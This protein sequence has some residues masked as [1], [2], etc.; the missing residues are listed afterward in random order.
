MKHLWA[1]WRRGY[2]HSL[3]RPFD[4]PPKDKGKE[5]GCL[6]CRAHKSDRRR[7][8]LGRGKNALVMMNLYP[9]AAGHLMVAPRRHVARPGLLRDEELLELWQWV[10]QSMRHLDQALHAEGYNIGVNIGRPAGAGIPG[11]MHIHVVPRWNGDTNFMPV[12]AS[13]KVI[14]DSMDSLY[15]ELKNC[16]SAGKN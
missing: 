6:F 9:Y 3:T 1:P 7:W 4:R 13:T 5:K 8:V 14:S 15:R 11:H 10:N 12:L 16:F 2:I